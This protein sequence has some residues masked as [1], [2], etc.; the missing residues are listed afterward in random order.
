MVLNCE[1]VDGLTCNYTITNSR[2][3]NNTA[4]ADGGVIKYDFYEPDISRNN[5][6]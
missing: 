6:F 2:F 3:I 5:T 4:Y 1:E